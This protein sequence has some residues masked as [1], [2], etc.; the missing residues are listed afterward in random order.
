MLLISGE[1]SQNQCQPGSMNCL[2]CSQRLFSCRGLPDGNNAVPGHRW[3]DQYVTCY[4]NRTVKVNKCASGM[5]DPLTRA[6]DNQIDKGIL[7]ETGTKEFILT[8]FVQLANSHTK[9]A[10]NCAN[11]HKLYSFIKIVILHVILNRSFRGK[12]VKVG[13]KLDERLRKV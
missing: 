5:F 6:C 13:A 12:M 1:Y 9:Y 11:D 2:P 4:R 3:S 10:M 7:N 8:K